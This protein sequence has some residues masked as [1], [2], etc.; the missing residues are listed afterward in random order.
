MFHHEAIENDRQ[1]RVLYIVC[2]DDNGDF[3]SPD[4]SNNCSNSALKRISLNVKLL[5]TFMCETLYK[6]FGVHKTFKFHKNDDICE[7][8]KSNLNLK[9]ALNMK[10]KDIF[11]YLAQE[12]AS[13]ADL[14]NPNHKYL[15]IL[16]FTRYEPSVKK[17][18]DDFFISTKGF[19]A[20]GAEWLAV[21][22]TSSLYTWPENLSDVQKYFLDNKFIDEKMF[23]NDTA[24]RNTYWA[25]YS[26]SLGSLLHEF[27]HILDLGHNK[28][29][30]M[31]RGFDDLFAFFTINFDNCFCYDKFKKHLTCNK[32]IERVVIKENDVKEGSKLVRKETIRAMF[33]NNS[34]NKKFEVISNLE[35]NKS[36]KLVKY[37]MNSFIKIFMLPI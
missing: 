27:S 14:Y 23:M 2:N 12:I 31:A 29:G 4:T 37:Y 33:K 22:G 35:W 1:I 6:K 19:C 20:L 7:L 16:S 9:Q 24:F 18:S 17:S 30:I 11:L 28:T 25:A 5:Q 15:A 8:Y 21:Y 3:Q 13:R 10:S 32:M 36:S 26:T 34:P